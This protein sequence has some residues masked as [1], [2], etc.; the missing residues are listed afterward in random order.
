MSKIK[1]VLTDAEKDTIKKLYNNY[2]QKSLINL[3]VATY[4][5]DQFNYYIECAS[6]SIVED[7]V[8]DQALL[9]FKEMLYN[10]FKIKLQTLCPHGDIYDDGYDTT[11]EFDEMLNSLTQQSLQLVR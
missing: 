2:K 8:V 9:N 6:R 7:R 10:N 4:N 3:D 1:I 5:N 11:D